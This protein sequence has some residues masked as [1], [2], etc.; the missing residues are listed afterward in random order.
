MK[1]NSK[2]KREYY[3]SSKKDNKKKKKKGSDDKYRGLNTIAQVTGS[4]KSHVFHSSIPITPVKNVKEPLPVCPDCGER[5]QSIA[6]AFSTQDGAYVH[7]DCMLKRIRMSETLS[8]KQS[9]SYV[10][11]GNFA[12]VEKDADGKYF[13]VKSIPVEDEKALRGMKEYVESLKV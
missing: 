13:I 12:I 4:P 5:I 2:A 6:E 8:E 7:F 11:K 3:S 10:G 9:I 1:K